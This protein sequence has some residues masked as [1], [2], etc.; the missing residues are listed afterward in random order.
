M[1]RSLTHKQQC[2]KL[3][4]KLN[5]RVNLLRKIAGSNWGA[6]AN[7][8]RSAALALVYSTGE[9]CAPVWE[10]SAHTAKIDVQLNEAMRVITSTVRS[11]PVQWLPVLANIPPQDLRRKAAKINLLKKVTSLKNSSLY[12]ILQD[13]PTTRLKSRKTPWADLESIN[14]FD[15]ASAWRQQWHKHPPNNAHLIEDP[16]RKVEGF[17]LPREAW[18]KLNRIRTGHGRCGYSLKKWGFRSSAQCDCGVEE[19]TIAHIVEECPLRKFDGDLRTLHNV[20]SSALDWLLNLDIC[21]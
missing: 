13:T 17:H 6:D 19:Q 8:L 11:T 5:S 10:N 21:L 16:T 2:M 14:S 3:S 12:E 1:D 20:T 9:Y 18:T 7:T 4:K 15:M